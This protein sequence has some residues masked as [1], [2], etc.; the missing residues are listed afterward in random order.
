MSDDWMN[1]AI[2]IGGPASPQPTPAPGAD[3]MSRA[4][5]LDKP[6]AQT[7]PVATVGHH[8]ANSLLMGYLPQLSAAASRVVYPAMNALTGQNVRPG[9]YTEE[10]D[11]VARDLAKE[12]QEN[13]RAAMAGKIGGAAI[14]SAI[15]PL[16]EL[17]WLGKGMIGAGAHGAAY[18]AAQG[19]LSNPGDKPGEID[20][21]QLEGREANAKTGALYGL[22]AG[23]GTKATQGLLGAVAKS[24]EYLK[25]LAETQ[26]FKGSGAMLRDFRAA[27]GKGMVNKLGRY[28]LDKGIIKFG[29]SVE[30]VARKSG[31][32]K[33]AAGEALEAIYGK[34]KEGLENPLV[35]EARPGMSDVGFNPV[36]DKKAILKQATDDLGDAEGAKGAV[37]RLETYLDDLGEKYGNQTLDPK[38]ATDIKG[39][40]D[41]VINYSRN[42]LQKNPVSEQ[43]FSSARNSVRER[44]AKDVD[45]LGAAT[46]DQDLAG[47]LSEANKDYGYSSQLNKIAKDRE[48]RENANRIFGLTDTIAGGAGGVAGAL[49]GGAASGDTKHGGEGALAGMLAMGLLNKTGRKYGPG[50]ISGA[51]EAG[52]PALRYTAAPV[53]EA[54]R[55]AANAVNPIVTSRLAAELAALKNKDKDK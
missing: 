42:P 40:M 1:R 43:A 8:A 51:A 29:D 41:K 2:P 54:L 23:L 27:E 26:A 33:D 34:A 9:S 10:R 55:P 53:A 37:S 3:W 52:A 35:S 21:L 11:Q 45:A 25:D 16:P 15:T 31:L 47:K 46:G 38:R 6:E 50:L 44:V 48:A 13:P 12:E 18:G 17:G 24:P 28:M 22:G 4:V 39:E 7:S 49:L 20:P 30:D 5:P 19:A 36:R 32:S 14:G